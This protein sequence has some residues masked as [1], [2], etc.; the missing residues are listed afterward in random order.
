M[1]IYEISSYMKLALS[2]KQRKVTH[3]CNDASSRDIDF[4]AIECIH[5][6]AI[7]AK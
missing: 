5:L 7:K 1:T 3:H 2:H 6:T 4:C